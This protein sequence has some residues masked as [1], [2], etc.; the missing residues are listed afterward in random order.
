MC[1]FLMICVR[2]VEQVDVVVD[3]TYAPNPTNYTYATFLKNFNITNGAYP[4]IDNNDVY[5]C[6]RAQFPDAATCL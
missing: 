3:E 1:M 5:R 2:C 6:A 4:F